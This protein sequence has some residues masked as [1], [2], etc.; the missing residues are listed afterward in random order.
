MMGGVRLV[1]VIVTEVV[2]LSGNSV[3]GRCYGFVYV[4]FLLFSVFVMSN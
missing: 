4:L 3:H 1:G 2:R